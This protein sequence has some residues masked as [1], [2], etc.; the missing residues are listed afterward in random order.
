MT[1]GVFEDFDKKE[2]FPAKE[3]WKRVR[4][5]HFIT[6]NMASLSPGSWIVTDKTV[7]TDYSTYTGQRV[8][9]PLD[10]MFVA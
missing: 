10:I 1:G 4:E 7:L 9:Q 8:M 2:S 6:I 5:I 3:S